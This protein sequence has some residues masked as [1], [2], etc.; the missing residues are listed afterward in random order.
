MEEKRIS[1]SESILNELVNV[2]AEH[3]YKEVGDLVNRAMQD[4]SA[5]NSQKEGKKND[6]K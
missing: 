5:N 2:V 1:I 6:G 4:V 3:S